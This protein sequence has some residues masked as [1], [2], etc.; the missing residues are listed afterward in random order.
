[1]K[2]L[3]VM[4]F[5]CGLV[6]QMPASSITILNPSFEDQSVPQGG[7]FNVSDMVIVD[8]DESD[9]NNMGFVAYSVFYAL[10]TEYPGGA[11][12]GVNVAQVFGDGRTA[13]IS[14]TL[15]ATLQAN[16][17]YTF[18][19]YAGLRLDTSA[20]PEAVLGC[21]AANA[22]VEAGGNILTPV[23]AL[24]GDIS[25][26]SLSLGNFTK[27]T[28]VFSTGTNPAGLGD[29]L[30]IVLTA[31]GSGSVSEPTEIDFDDISMSDTAGS[32][33]PSPSAPEPATF[34]TM[35]SA[36]AIGIIILRRRTAS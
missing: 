21:A 1:M 30:E 32:N 29:P 34:G 11:P 27:F 36:L 19:G 31:T 3:S 7:P 22:A 33:S 28:F 10:P 12:D 24:G 2:Y 17:T 9:P 5:A 15:S 35:A 6:T 25:C 4:L 18:T 20:F 13:F 23:G 26:S 8:W 14:Q 16:D